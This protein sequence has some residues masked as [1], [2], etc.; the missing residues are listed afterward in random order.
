MKYI[1]Y[2]SLILVLSFFST[3]CE[4]SL[5]INDDPLAATSADPNVLLPFV[6]VLTVQE[7]VQLQYS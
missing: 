2:L 6:H 5:D 4:D 7:R 1:K 3:S